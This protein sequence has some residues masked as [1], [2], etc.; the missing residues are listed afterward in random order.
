MAPI[1]AAMLMMLCQLP[2]GVG[3]AAVEQIGV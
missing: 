1:A 3:M 2:A